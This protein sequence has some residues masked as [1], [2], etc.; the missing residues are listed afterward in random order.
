MRELSRLVDVVLVV[1]S[2]NSSNM[3]RLREIAEE[4]CAHSHLIADGSE[5][6]AAWVRDAETIGITA[7]VSTP[8]ALV[9][10]VLAA[11]GRLTADMSIDVLSGKQERVVFR[12]PEARS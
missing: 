9:Q 1:G 6:R 2:S 5:L 4:A 11:L 3:Q 7:S 10:D 8:D 12:L